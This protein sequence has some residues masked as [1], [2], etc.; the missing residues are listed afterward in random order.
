MRCS[1][2]E[3]VV[4]QQSD[5]RRA[6]PVPVAS[7]YRRS[8]SNRAATR[9]VGV[10][11][12]AGGQASIV[13]EL[14]VPDEVTVGPSSSAS[15]A[16][17]HPPKEV[18]LASSGDRLV[19]RARLD[20]DQIRSSRELP[21]DR[22]RGAHH[23]AV[24]AQE[25]VRIERVGERIERIE[26]ISVQHSRLSTRRTGRRGSTVRRRLLSPSVVG[27]AN[28]SGSSS[29]ARAMA[30]STSPS[31]NNSIRSTI[32]SRATTTDVLTTPS[33]KSLE[34]IDGD[35]CR[36]EDHDPIRRRVELNGD[37]AR[38]V[39]RR[40]ER[41]AH[42][43]HAA[44]SRTPIPN[45]R[46]ST[47]SKFSA[48]V[49][50]IRSGRALRAVAPHVD[51]RVLIDG[52]AC[53]TACQRSSRSS[54]ASAS[55][56]AGKWRT[57]GE[58]AVFVDLLDRP[59]PLAAVDLDEQHRQALADHRHDLAVLDAEADRFGLALDPSTRSDRVTSVSRAHRATKSPAKTRWRI[60]RSRRG[61]S[62]YETT[63]QCRR[64]SFVRMPH[65]G[66][67]QAPRSEPSRH[68]ARRVRTAPNCVTCPDPDRAVRHTRN[69]LSITSPS[70]AVDVEAGLVQ[71]ALPSERRVFAG[72]RRRIRPGRSPTT[73]GAPAASSR[74]VSVPASDGA[75]V[76]QVDVGME[77]TEH[78]RAAP[79]GR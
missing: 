47:N 66:G 65:V 42:S 3:C 7:R 15:S 41:T 11:R 31:S 23:R 25:G 19:T 78:A 30:P 26:V 50:A 73:R 58:A 38:R 62:R 32:P 72:C 4:G 52:G 40:T 39:R 68:R 53:S 24:I 6:D 63:V 45:G 64:S 16:P 14:R 17:R 21:C 43:S 1:V 59:A 44:R 54:I 75:V 34:S 13:A 61:G 35:H 28:P 57:S 71:G 37:R 56:S 20:R 27:A 46:W 18:Q 49:S 8:S 10:E 5:D 55:E 77:R 12:R 76:D 48:S 69:R 36:L 70:R 33:H 67:N 74:P 9:S 29:A 2:H 51:H 22:R 79:C 60:V